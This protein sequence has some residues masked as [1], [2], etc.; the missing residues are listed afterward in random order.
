MMAVGAPP[1]VPIAAASATPAYISRLLKYAMLPPCETD[2][3]EHALWVAAAQA[4]HE[5]EL[6]EAESLAGRAFLGKIDAD[7]I[8]RFAHK[9]KTFV[10][11]AAATRTTD[12]T[13][14][15]KDFLRVCK[16][17][18]RDPT[19]E[20][21]RFLR[22]LFCAIDRRKRGVVTT[23]EIATGLV[24][25]CNE[26]KLSKMRCLFQIFNNIDSHCLMYDEIF[27]M[28]RCVKAIDI[29]KSRQQLVTD[30]T[31]NDELSLQEAK[32]LYEVVI[33]Y[34]RSDYDL[35]VYEE[36]M[37][38][39]HQRPYLLDSVLPG[40]FSLDWMFAEYSPP[41]LEQNAYTDDA[42]VGFTQA[43][44]HN[45]ERLELSEPRGRG[46]RVM[47]NCLDF[48]HGAS[49]ALQPRKALP[50]L[51]SCAASSSSASASSRL[52]KTPRAGH[53]T[54]AS[55]KASEATPTPTV[56]NALPALAGTA[57]PSPDVATVTLPGSATATPDALTGHASPSATAAA[58]ASAAVPGL[59]S[60]VGSLAF[61]GC[62]IA[63]IPSS[64][65]VCND[66]GDAVAAGGGAPD[67]GDSSDDAGDAL[68]FL[69]SSAQGVRSSGS[70]AATR[71]AASF[72]RQHSAAELL[73]L[74]RLGVA[75]EVTPLPPVRMNHEDAKRFRKMPFDKK[76]HQ[77]FLREQKAMARML[78]Y[79]GLMETLRHTSTE[80]SPRAH[81]TGS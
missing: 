63:A 58:A 35:I 55:C 42:I 79:R 67:G 44:R 52:R 81:P 53:S 59:G 7:F 6:A 12:M 51:T 60:A 78:K 4:V 10:Q 74:E 5:E 11:G 66:G 62:Q 2:G 36:F 22:R 29:T 8:I 31:F 15:L 32:R 1:R 16:K 77:A 75:A 50:K 26:D 43:L 46:H 28:F 57:S 24:L 64:A 18:M 72:G 21:G 54:T 45:E 65:N 76:A 3:P 13:V 14:G 25:I 33:S 41:V 70:G 61:A 73:A 56:P 17:Q 68:L 48:T 69:K 80:T 9:L 20:D 71:G 23:V 38:V 34:L 37:D 40:I 49:D 39:F 19:P 30:L 47:S 27:E